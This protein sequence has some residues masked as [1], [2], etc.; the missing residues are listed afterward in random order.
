MSAHWPEGTILRWKQPQDA[1]ERDERYVVLFDCGGAV[2][3][4]ELHFV[5]NPDW[6][7]PPVFTHWS[8]ELEAECQTCGGPMERG[9]RECLRC[10][11]DK[12]RNLEARDYFVGDGSLQ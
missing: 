1:T 8:S 10:T 3:T 9:L 4:T 7:I 6:P 2:R 11:T 12:S 5:D